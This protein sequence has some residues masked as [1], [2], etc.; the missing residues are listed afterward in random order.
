MKMGKNCQIGC[1][2]CLLAS[3]LNAAPVD[4]VDVFSGTS[5]SRWM[6]FPGPTLPFGM[7]KLSP[8]NQGN[9][10]NGG[11]EY[12][13]HSISG[14][15]HLHSFSLSGLSVMPYVGRFGPERTYPGQ[16]DGP[17]G[18]MWTAGY[19]SR[20]DKSTE[21]GRPGYYSVYLSDWKVSV[22]L[23]ATLRCGFMRFR[24]PTGD[25]SRL[26]LDQAFPTEQKTRILSARI[27]RVGRQ[28]IEGVVR[29]HNGYSGEYDLHFVLKASQPIVSME[30]WQRG[31][32]TSTFDDYGRD[33]QIPAEIRKD[34]ASF[35]GRDGCGVA[36]RFRTRDGKPLLVQTALSFVSVAQ[37]RKNM[38]EELG[39]VGWDFDQVVK[40]ARAA[41]SEVLDVVE[42]EGTEKQR[43]LFYTNL[44]RAYSAKSILH[45]VDGRY[46]NSKGVTRRLGKASSAVY[47]G[48]AFWGSQWTL[49]P[50]WTLLS[51]RYA[52]SWIGFFLEAYRQGGWMPQA[53]VRGGYSPVMVAQHHQSLIVSAYQK[54]IRGFDADTAWE[55]IRH[56]LTTP[57]RELPNGGYAGN[58][59][60]ASYL[61]LGYVPVEDGPS[62]NTF[63]YA[64]DDYAA[65]NFAL[66]LGKQKE[67][68]EFLRRSRSWRNAIHP[69]DKFARLRRADGTW[70]R[71]ADPHKFGTE[72][73]WNGPGF[74]E[75]TPWLY[76]WFVPQ[77]PRG[78]AELMGKDEFN[79][80]LEE[81]FEKG[82]VDIG[83]ET[84]LHAPFLFN[85]SG[86][87]W[88]TQREVRKALL[89]AWDLEAVGGWRRGEED[90][91]QLGAL[92]VLWSLGLFQ[93]DGGVTAD[94]VYDLC[95]PLHPRA[96]LKVGPDGG[97]RFTIEALNASPENAY[98]QSAKL[99]GKTLDRA[100][101]THRE[102]SAGGHL[103]FTL[104]PKPNKR[105]GL[106][107]HGAHAP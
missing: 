65:G 53:P 13:V 14:F 96:V 25:E 55:A 103:T 44:Y 56:D 29:Q 46:V 36:L 82:W 66:A 45:D 34:C 24:F 31:K 32:F 43:A 86:Q 26:L 78:L 106:I 20:I 41:W 68:D 94:S 15:S 85:H 39:G 87:P 89:D 69:G 19:R 98:V 48:D 93:M 57:G 52:R 72:G 77:D 80:R 16:P 81:G 35:E 102:I 9:V 22:E 12:T 47:S 73:G 42:I 50:L 40:R 95:A 60:L 99:N 104:G 74:V 3:N 4:L 75:G 2:V 37:A 38:R 8:D 88:K 91:G 61:R 49:F 1:I 105:W 23:T 10:W 90:E 67:A 27:R 107:P 54:G 92:Y 30:G 83:N 71:P 6:L 28:E 76:T 63:E 59:N 70:V 97:K 100:W 101:I 5:N 51:P 21:R 62:S 33:W 11:Y 79:R 84:N 64:F 58:R 7:V 17:F 18:G